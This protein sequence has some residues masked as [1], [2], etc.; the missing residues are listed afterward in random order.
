MGFAIAKNKIKT[1]LIVAIIAVVLYLL[2]YFVADMMGYG[3]YAIV[4]AGGVSIITSLVSYWN[5]AKLALSA[6]GAKKATGQDEA[7]LRSLITPICEEAGIPVPELY[8]I[9]DNSPNA[10]ATGRN[11]SHAAVAATRGIMN[12]LSQDK[13]RGVV[14]HEI[15]H[16]KNYDI[17]LQ[18]VASIMVGAIIIISDIFSRSLLWGGARRRSDRD[19]GNGLLAIIGLLLMIFAPIAAQ[20]LRMCLSRNR[21]YLADATAADLTGRPEALASALLKISGNPTPV[22]RASRATEGLYISDPLKKMANLFSTHPPIEKRVEA[23]RNMR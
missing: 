6:N 23:L 19:S 14:A 2:V 18:T 21:E 11:P 9:E 10:F 17:L 16:I 20:L 22:M 5:S 8:V 12:T 7:Y 13:L 3:N 15:G 1:F 4:I